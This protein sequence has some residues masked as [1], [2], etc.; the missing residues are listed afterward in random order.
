MKKNSISLFYYIS[1]LDEVE[2]G[3]NII[4]H[5]CSV[6]SFDDIII[7]SK[8]DYIDLS[9]FED[10][11][12]RIVRDDLDSS[13]SSYNF[14]IVNRLSDHIKTD[15][16]LTI[17][18]DG[19]IINSSSW[20]DENFN[21]DYIGAPWFNPVNQNHLRVGNGGFS[22]RSK[23]LLEAC[24]KISKDIDPQSIGNEDVFICHKS[25]DILE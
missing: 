25:K 17:Q 7:L 15:Y 9:R 19:F 6:F 4:N 20:S 14:F 18:K 12:C 11:G 3:L 24:K 2:V 5:C 22:L 16:V 1:S 8:F 23:K 10:I 21:Y 13:Y